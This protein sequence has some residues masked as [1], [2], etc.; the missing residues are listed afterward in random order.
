MLHDLVCL[1][2]LISWADRAASEGNRYPTRTLAG[3]GPADLQSA[4][5]DHLFRAG[6]ADFLSA[7]TK[8]LPRVGFPQTLDR[9][10]RPC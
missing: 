9:P 1:R 6:P 7:V 10:A 2:S 8:L 4:G 5:V 3:G